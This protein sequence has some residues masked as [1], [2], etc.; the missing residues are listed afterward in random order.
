MKSRWATSPT[1]TGAVDAGASLST[2]LGN[3]IAQEIPRHRNPIWSQ[4]AEDRLTA[5]F[6]ADGHHL[7]QDVLKVMLRAKGVGRSVLVSDSVDL[8]RHAPRYLHHSCGGTS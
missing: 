5:T 6:I 3:G 1:R 2:H 4:L 7:P 8:A